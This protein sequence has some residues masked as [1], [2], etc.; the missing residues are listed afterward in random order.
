[1]TWTGESGMGN[2]AQQRIVDRATR[3]ADFRRR[4]IESPQQAI[5]EELGT[6]VSSSATIRVIEEQPGEVVLVLPARG[7]ESGARLTDEDLEGAAGGATATASVCS[8]CAAGCPS[9]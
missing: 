4:L 7:M 2:Q 9:P 3:D 6:S 5:Q 1:M 8:T